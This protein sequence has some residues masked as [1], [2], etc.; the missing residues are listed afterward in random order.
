M[1]KWIES[2]SN[3]AYLSI[4]YRNSPLFPYRI[5]KTALPDYRL[6]QYRLFSSDPIRCFSLGTAE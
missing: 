3:V 2:L 5:K 1:R 4:L 6:K